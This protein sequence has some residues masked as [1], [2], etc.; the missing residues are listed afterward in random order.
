MLVLPL[1][2]GLNSEPY[3]EES[4]KWVAL[5]ASEVGQHEVDANSLQWI[6]QDAESE[7]NLFNIIARVLEPNQVEWV[8]TINIDC[9]RN[10]FSYLNGSKFEHGRFLGGFDKAKPAEPIVAGSMPDQLKQ[11]YCLVVA[12]S[13]ETEQEDESA[14]ISSELEPADSNAPQTIP[15]SK[16]E[17]KSIGK[18]TIAEVFYDSKS[19]R[20]SKDGLRFIAHTRVVPFSSSLNS[21]QE[22]E[23]TLSTLS[24][25][26]ADHTF[27]I[28]RMSKLVDGQLISIFDTPQPPAHTDKI[29]TIQTLASK[30]CA[31]QNNST[32]VK[33]PDQIKKEAR[34][35]NALSK[36]ETLETNIE[37][38]IDGPGLDCK[39]TKIYVKQIHQLAKAVKRDDC[40]IDGLESFAQQV[41]NEKCH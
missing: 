7:K 29:A 5:G 10:S 31:N 36:V 18:S 37:K 21:E 16:I 3:A 1:I 40:P 15:S 19:I 6:A 41:K 20:R 8:M 13:K 22:G 24:F 39:Q 28:V 35:T 27:M 2:F 14:P 32:Q 34:C 38:G 17:W 12:Q 9:G 4:A 30:F 33:S 11:A 25:D 23:V 26:C